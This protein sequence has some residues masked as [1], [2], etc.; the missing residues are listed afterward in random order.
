MPTT[1]TKPAPK[2]PQARL[3]MD[4]KVARIDKVTGDDEN[5]HHQVGTTVLEI[6]EENLAEKCGYKSA[7]AFMKVELKTPPSTLMM[8]SKV[9]KSFPEATAAKYGMTRLHK[10]LTLAKLLNTESVPADPG[11]F[12]L[13][14]PNKKAELNA[15]KFKDCS[16]SEV[17]AA[18]DVQK[19][20]VAEALPPEA[21]RL[22]ASAQAEV[23]RICGESSSATIKASL[24][25]AQVQFTL[26]R[27]PAE[28]LAEVSKAI[29]ALAPAPD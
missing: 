26:S 28:K 27:V 9:A 10:F 19:Q 18:I 23:D 22:Q 20:P 6:L 8:Y 4:G 29:A 11:E 21:V 25:G 24:H 13:L 17:Q 15:K 7:Y 3:A 16:V 12:E 5:E 2:D 14:V 1:L